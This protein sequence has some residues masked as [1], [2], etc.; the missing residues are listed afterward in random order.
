[1]DDHGHCI[2]LRTKYSAGTDHQGRRPEDRRLRGTRDPN[3]N[4]KE[5]LLTVQSLGLV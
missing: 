4:R 3:S 5:I 1:M 2:Q